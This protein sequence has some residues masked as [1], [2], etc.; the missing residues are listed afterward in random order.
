MPDVNVKVG[1]NKKPLVPPTPPSH[2]VLN[3]AVSL[4]ANILIS[5]VTFPRLYT[6]IFIF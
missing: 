6:G 3:F 5:H 2:K 4:S 1:E